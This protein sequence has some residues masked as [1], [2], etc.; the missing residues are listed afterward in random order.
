VKAKFVGRYSDVDFTAM[1]RENHQD[2][3]L[4]L[5]NLETTFFERLFARMI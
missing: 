1:G 2:Q 4:P 3:S 5:D